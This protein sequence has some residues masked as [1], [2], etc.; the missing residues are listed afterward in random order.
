VICGRS[1]LF[2]ELNI[3][4]AAL[5]D[6]G[7]HILKIFTRDVARATASDENPARL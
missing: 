5:R 3:A 2:E 4:P 1:A 6:S 7:E